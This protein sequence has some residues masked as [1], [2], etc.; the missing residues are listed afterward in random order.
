MNNVTTQVGLVF[1]GIACFMAWFAGGVRLI[2]WAMR[3]W[4]HEYHVFV[5]AWSAYCFVPGILLVLLGAF[6]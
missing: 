2:D 3:R 4:G 1:I 6:I 5:I